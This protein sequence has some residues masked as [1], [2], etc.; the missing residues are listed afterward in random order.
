M[1][2]FEKVAVARIFWIYFMMNCLIR[3]LAILRKLF[4]YDSFNFYDILKHSLQYANELF[5]SEDFFSA[6]L[7]RSFDS[8]KV[9]FH[10]LDTLNLECFWFALR[11][12]HV[13]KNESG[14]HKTSD[15]CLHFAFSLITNHFSWSSQRSYQKTQM[16]Y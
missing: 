11:M 4:F 10:Q 5:S 2:P 1:F 9:D 6:F 8:V 14:T 15:L 16:K 12:F 13:S 3:R 7:S